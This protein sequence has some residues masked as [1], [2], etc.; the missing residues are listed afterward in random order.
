[1]GKKVKTK[2]IAQLLV[3]D[4][5]ESFANVQCVIKSIGKTVTTKNNNV[6]TKLK[7]GDDSTKDMMPLTYWHNDGKEAHEFNEG[8]IVCITR[9]YV[10]TDNYTYKNPQTQEDVAVSE[11]TL[12]LSKTSTYGPA[13]RIYK[14]P[15]MD[16]AA[17]HDLLVRLVALM[18]KA[19]VDTGAYG[20][21]IT[22]EEID[23]LV[24]EVTERGMA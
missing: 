20:I 23:P 5:N 12:N 10:K 3:A 22:D 4:D 21:E 1:M 18:M 2:N 15:T 17:D 19:G 13:G 8:D 14:V 7:V 24:K 11:K 6:F 9:G 16:A